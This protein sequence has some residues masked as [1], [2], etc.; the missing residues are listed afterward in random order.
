MKTIKKSQLINNGTAL[1]NLF[2]LMLRGECGGFGNE[3]PDIYD[4]KLNCYSQAGNVIYTFNNDG[5]V[6]VEYGDDFKHNE[7]YNIFGEEYDKHSFEELD[8]YYPEYYD[9]YKDLLNS[10]D[11][12]FYNLDL[13]ISIKELLELE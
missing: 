9:S 2:W 5:S 4:N 6:D 7:L 12:W 10:A 1:A 11:G 3:D 13:N 8:E